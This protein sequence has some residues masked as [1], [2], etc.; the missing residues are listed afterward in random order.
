M[1]PLS[2]SVLSLVKN[3]GC[4]CVEVGVITIVPGRFVG[5][6]KQTGTCRTRPS[7]QVLSTG[8]LLFGDKVR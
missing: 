4:V 5:Q 7:I 8:L 2:A 3:G 1:S 6:S